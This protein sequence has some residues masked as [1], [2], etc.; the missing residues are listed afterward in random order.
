MLNY[1]IQKDNLLSNIMHYCLEIIPGAYGYF[2]N[3]NKFINKITINN[4]NYINQF[5]C[6]INNPKQVKAV[7]ASGYAIALIENPNYQILNEFYNSNFKIALTLNE[8]TKTY[9]NLCD[10]FILKSNDYLD[11]KNIKKDIYLCGFN[12]IENLCEI[13]I[14]EKFTGIVIE[15]LSDVKF[16]KEKYP[17][18]NFICKNPSDTKEALKYAN[19]II[20]KNISVKNEYRK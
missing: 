20:K 10:F 3:K 4:I 18:L 16:Y 13:A 9:E 2:Y 11:Y 17:K 6:E 8:K 15:G 5:I 14:N 1:I 12:S 7:F 19:F